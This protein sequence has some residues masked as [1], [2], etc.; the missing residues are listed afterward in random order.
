MVMHLQTS[1]KK[2]ISSEHHPGS[3][4]LLGNISLKVNSKLPELVRSGLSGAGP[5]GGLR[6]NAVGGDGADT[7]VHLKEKVSPLV[8]PDLSHTG[9]VLHD[10]VDHT[11]RE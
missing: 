3:S 4:C 7:W 11:P 8:H 5:S 6:R 10:N 2:S 1:C 9:R